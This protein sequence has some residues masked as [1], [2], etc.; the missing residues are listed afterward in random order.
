MSLAV[1]VDSLVVS[2]VAAAAGLD[3][4]VEPPEGV[5]GTEGGM[6]VAALAEGT[7]VEARETETSEEAA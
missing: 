4:M 5:V 3:S 1:M 7:G 6:E 2:G